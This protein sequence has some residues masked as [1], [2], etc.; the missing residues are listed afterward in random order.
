MSLKGAVVLT[1]IFESDI[2]DTYFKN[3]RRYERLSD[4]QMIVIPDR[5]TPASV[6]SRCAAIKAGRVVSGMSVSHRARRILVA[7]GT[8]FAPSSLQFR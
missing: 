8:L 6:F 5:K 3:F 1:T 7:I 2:L 4:V